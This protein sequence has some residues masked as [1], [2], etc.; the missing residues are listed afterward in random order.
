MTTLKWSEED[1]QSRTKLCL[2]SSIITNP[3]SL[4]DSFNN[5]FINNLL[6]IS[7]LKISLFLK[8]G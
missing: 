8:G 6:T 7:L 5:F 4:A 2:D 1:L 3:Q